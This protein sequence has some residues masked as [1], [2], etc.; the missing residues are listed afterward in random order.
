MNYNLNTITEPE[1]NKNEPRSKKQWPIFK[2]LGLIKEERLLVTIAFIA[3]IINS[4]ANLIGPY[5]IGRAIDTYVVKGMLA[6][7]LNA[8][9]VLL[10]M[11]AVAFV[12]N[13]FQIKSMGTVGQRV[14]FRV[15][16]TIFK[17]LEELP[18]EFFSKNKAGDLISR[19]NNDTQKLSQFFTEVLTQIFGNIL[20]ITG[21]GI[22]LISLNV[23][24]GVVTLL[25]A[26]G[27]IILTRLT[28]NMVEKANKKGLQAG[29]LL[30]A[31]VQEGLQNFKV[32]VAFN[33]RDYFR[34]Q[35]DA[36]NQDNYKAN[37]KSGS[38]NGIFMPVYDFA[39]SLGQYVVLVYGI[40]LIAG[41][42]VTIGLLVAFLAYAEKFYNPL[43]H[44]AH[45]WS[46]MQ[47]SLAAWNRISAILSLTSNMPILE[48]GASN[49][50]S[51]IDTG[52]HADAQAKKSALLEF[53]NVSFHYSNEDGEKI[54]N[55]L[56]HASFE[57]E[58]GK[59]YALVGPTG[60]GKTTTASLM[61]RL[62]DPSEGTILLKG[63]D[64]RTYTTPVR[65]ASIGFILQDPIIFSGTLRENF[66]YGNEEYADLTSEELL[67]VLKEQGLEDLLERF[68]GG[69]D[70][71]LPKNIDSMSL[72]QKQILAFVR[73]VLRKPDLLILDEATA[74]IDRVTEQVLERILEK[75]P[76][77]TT[78]VVIAHRLNTI[79]NADVIFFVNG[80]KITKAGS[81][82]DALDMLLKGKKH[83]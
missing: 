14:L 4:T 64:I 68:E 80:S 63:K 6:G 30:S 50:A 76:K 36:I 8:V 69:L 35:F 1:K 78:K 3:L 21:A 10:V 55:V 83:S 77:T 40:Y 32:I 81:M 39:A 11:Y 16:N 65:T 19:I 61:A 46:S 49:I 62:F 27:L 74:N 20:I 51:T 37:F 9:L 22:F 44:M 12:A 60:G 67:V 2:L 53:K 26:L 24:L 75:L 41:G 73:A 82:Q 47:V 58:A 42:S 18:L 52:A 66:V 5:L 70:A 7:L 17:K 54:K 33:R 43:R 23:K 25:P 48:E 57:L 29:G 59:T 38:L 31:E 34:K 72:G 13:Y 71:D 15:R 79:Q 56:E 45:L 28:S